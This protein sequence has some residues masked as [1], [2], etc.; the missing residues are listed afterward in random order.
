MCLGALTL[1]LGLTVLAPAS[2]AA[3]TPPG[4]PDGL[5]I[6]GVNAPGSPMQPAKK[7]E[8]SRVYVGMYVNDIQQLNMQDFTYT[9][10]FYLWMRWKGRDLDP[11]STLDIM[12]AAEAWG[13]MVTPLYE[14][15]QKQPDGSLLMVTRY[16]GKFN[17]EMPLQ[18]YPF[19]RQHLIAEFEDTILTGKTLEFVPDNPAIALNPDIDL[20]GYRIGTATLTVRDQLY[21]STF[22][23]Q[24]A[25]APQ[26]YSR[27]VADIP[28][29]RPY[30]ANALKTIFPIFLVAITGSFVFFIAANLVESR[31]GMAI[32]ALLTLVA[33]Q[34]TTTSMLP[35]VEYLMMIDGLYVIS[36]VFVIFALGVAVWNSRGNHD[37][38]DSDYEAHQAALKTRDTR[39]AAASITL[40][41]VAVVAMAVAFLG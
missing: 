4:L 18:S 2:A 32:T 36:Y 34:F 23:D 12:N 31:I 11:P 16:Q 29:T 35:E 14:E 1:L 8:P 6:P 3:A 5:R 9:L 38:E 21:D 22:G 25:T 7:G 10:D 13:M 17:N 15:P 26:T 27:F 39:L 20:P 33:L 19:D 28:I 24:A 40:Y 37:P 30:L 41:A